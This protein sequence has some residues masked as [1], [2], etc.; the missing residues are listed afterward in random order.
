MLTLGGCR[1]MVPCPEMLCTLARSGGVAGEPCTACGCRGWW[2]HSS[3]PGHQASDSICCNKSEISL[4]YVELPVLGKRVALPVLSSDQDETRAGREELGCGYSLGR[5]RYFPGRLKPPLSL[6]NDDAR[7]GVAQQKE[8]RGHSSWSF[9]HHS[10]QS[11]LFAASLCYV[12]VF[13][14]HVLPGCPAPG[15]RGA[16]TPIS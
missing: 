5:H 3:S 2:V 16:A 4:A 8:D 12:K 15:T 14:V 13:C 9:Q 1:R 10:R 11:G 7:S 6:I